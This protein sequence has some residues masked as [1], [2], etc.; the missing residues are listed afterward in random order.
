MLSQG[1]APATPVVVSGVT[2]LKGAWL[3][4][5]ETAAEGVR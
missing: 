5:G 4:L 2:T 1:V 3:G